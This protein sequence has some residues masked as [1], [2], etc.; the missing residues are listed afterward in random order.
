M[1]TSLLFIFI[2]NLLIFNP[3]NQNV[4]YSTKCKQKK[5][6]EIFSCD[7]FLSFIHGIKESESILFSNNYCFT[8]IVESND[9]SIY[10]HNYRLDHSFNMKTQKYHFDV[11]GLV[12]NEYRFEYI[13]SSERNFEKY[14]ENLIEYGFEPFHETIDDMYKYTN[15]KYHY[16]MYLR[17]QTSLETTNYVITI[18]SRKK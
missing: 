14:K 10:Y 15:S 16:N 18:A 13:T 2:V 12:K 17:T 5:S 3:I 4:E 1:K 8:G 6:N 9:K 7:S 11:F